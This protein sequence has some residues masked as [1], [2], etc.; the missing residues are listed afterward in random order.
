MYMEG[1]CS[2]LN[3][4]LSTQGRIS[5]ASYHHE[6]AQSLSLGAYLP[7]SRIVFASLKGF[8]S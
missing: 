1:I 6:G 2:A 3:K 5:A 7:T 8:I 4:S